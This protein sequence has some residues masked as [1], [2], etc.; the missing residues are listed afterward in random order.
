MRIRRQT[1]PGGQVLDQTYQYSKCS[2]RKRALFVGINYKGQP[3]EL[4]GCVND[5]KNMCKFMMSASITISPPPPLPFLPFLS[6]PFPSLHL[7]VWT[8]PCHILYIT[9]T[10]SHIDRYAYKPE[11]IVLLTD[12]SEHARQLPTKKNITDAMRWLVRGAK[13]HDSLFFHCA[14]DFPPLS[15]P[16]LSSPPLSSHLP[17]SYTPPPLFFFV[18]YLCTRWTSILIWCEYWQ[19]RDMGARRATW[20]ETR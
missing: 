14:S 6:L 18:H 5:A 17:P 1:L 15:S 16:P 11:D 20:M 3:N 13:A 12:D 10:L 2:G 8:V 7:T 9:D 4:E 19:I